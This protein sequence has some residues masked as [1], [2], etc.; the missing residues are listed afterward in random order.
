M[1]FEQGLQILY[2]PLGVYAVTVGSSAEALPSLPDL[3]KLRRVVVRGLGQPW[4]WR[5]DG[6]DP[7]GSNGFHQLADEIVVFDNDFSQLKLVR[8]STATADVDMR[9]AYYGL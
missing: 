2:N 5:D 8:A 3:G 7:D 9:I 1:L 6:V 4:E